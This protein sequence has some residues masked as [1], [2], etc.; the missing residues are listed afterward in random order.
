MSVLI[1]IDT[2]EGQ[3]KKSSFEALC[4]GA[5]VAEQL[6]THAEGVLLGECKDDVA[7]LGKYG[8]KKIYHIADTVLNTLDA[9][10]Y[11]H[12][13]TEVAKAAGSNV[14]VVS[15]NL[16]GKAIAPRISVRLKAGL[17]AGA[18]ALPDTSNGFVATSCSVDLFP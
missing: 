4:Y 7:S 2:A 5:K 10:V 15:N 11:A 6:G 16:S 18:N 14:L 17:V 9:Q 3:V 13:I 8:V 12:A 1:F